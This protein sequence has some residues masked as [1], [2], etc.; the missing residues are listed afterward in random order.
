MLLLTP[1]SNQFFK[2]NRLFGFR[3]MRIREEEFG[4]SSGVEGLRLRYESRFFF[5]IFETERVIEHCSLPRANI[6]YQRRGESPFVVGRWLPMVI[7]YGIIPADYPTAVTF[8][9]LI[10]LPTV[11]TTSVNCNS[12]CPNDDGKYHFVVGH[13]LFSK[14][15]EKKR[16]ET[17]HLRERKG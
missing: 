7:L 8:S 2:S 1:F 10:L 3:R 11:P 15:K 4:E 14:K 9:E 16:K 12:E 6:R 5:E 13:L 17:L